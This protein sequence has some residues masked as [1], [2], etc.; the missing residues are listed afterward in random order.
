[1]PDSSI[2][3]ETTKNAISYQETSAAFAKDAAYLLSA[4]GLRA[5][6]WSQQKAREY[7]DA[8]WSRLARLIGV[9]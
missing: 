7:H 8:A 5:A 1:M 9:E 2:V 4:N 6:A 3:R